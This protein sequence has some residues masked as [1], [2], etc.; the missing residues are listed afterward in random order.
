MKPINLY[1]ENI[2]EQFCGIRHE[3]ALLIMFY[4]TCHWHE[5]Y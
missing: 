5:S 3:R 2:L 4:F 1:V